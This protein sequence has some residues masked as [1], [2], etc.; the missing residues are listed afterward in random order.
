MV[1]KI[2]STVLLF[3]LFLSQMLSLANTTYG[4]EQALALKYK[5]LAI[6]KEDDRLIIGSILPIVDIKNDKRNE[7][8][9]T[10][11]GY[12]RIFEWNGKTFEPKWKSPQFS[13]QYSD[14]RF[15]FYEISPLVTASYYSGKQLITDYLFFAYTS[16]KSSDIYRVTWKDNKYELQ[17]VSASP[18]NWFGFSGTCGDGSSIIIG[19]KQH[20][21]GNYDVVYKWN[22]ST[23]VEV[24]R[25]APGTRV[26]T[27]GEMLSKSNNT[28][29]VM[30]VQANQKAGI[31]ACQDG[32]I[33]W[34]EIDLR[35]DTKDVSGSR[36]DIADGTIGFTKKNSIGELWTVQH[37]TEAESD[38]P[39]KLY[40]SQF[41]GKRFSSFSRVNFKGINS[42]MIHKVIIVYVDNDG[43][44]EILGV[45]DKIRKTIPRK[46]PEDESD[47]YLITSNLF[48]AKWNG[49]EYEVKWHRKAIDERVRNI[50]V[51]DVTGDGNKEI[52]ITDDNGYLYV[53]D[54]PTD[55]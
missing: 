18:F 2:I 48:L 27:T 13:Y 19:G 4:A 3:G 23:L 43:V 28:K 35:V 33:E 52:L 54:M 21:N 34:K 22:G 49:K 53:F 24:W 29:N 6:E 46:H 9:I 1:K 38:Y 50:A 31:L 11:N 36:I 40:V 42:D 16:P 45:E 44:G 10:G 7:I 8:A 32:S 55:R 26:V 51:G 17:K 47:T 25:G 12:M 15:T 14:G 5:T 37:P 30:L 20:Q 41:D 39:T